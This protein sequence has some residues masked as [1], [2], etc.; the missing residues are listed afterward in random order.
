MTRQ[1]KV[2]YRITVE[3]GREY[4]YLTLHDADGR[5]VKEHEESFRQPFLLDR[6]DA[7]EEAVDCWHSIWQWISDTC[8]FPLPDPEGDKRDS[9][10]ED[11]T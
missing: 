9:G 11:A 8:V 2:E 7:L 4:V 5:L 1:D 3:Y 10:E 6:K